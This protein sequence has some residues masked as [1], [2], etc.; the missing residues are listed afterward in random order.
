MRIVFFGSPEAALPALSALLAAGHE[1]PLVV[2]QPDRPAGRGRLPAPSPVKAF[3]VGLGLPT[4]EPERIRKDPGAVDRLRAA[5]P[6]IQ[7]VVAYGQIMPGPIIDLPPHRS[8]NLHFSLL[9][10]YRGA[11]PASWAIRRGEKKTGVTIFRLNEKMDEGDIY[12]SAEEPIGPDDTTGSL[13]RRLA[14]IGSGLLVRTLANLD[15]IA[16]RPQAH[17]AATYAPKLKKADGA[18]DW[19]AEAADVDRHIRSMTPWPTAFGFL[20]DERLIILAGRPHLEAGSPP[21]AYEPG[22]VLSVG[23][24]GILIACGGGT[25]Y[26]IARLQPEGRKTMDAAAYLAGGKIRPGL[27]LTPAPRV[28][29]GGAD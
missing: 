1:V 19:N 6:D 16:P 11:A 15:T 27:R 21:A 28:P 17:E 8:L 14:Q 12:A 10:A 3:A 7:V 4:Y 5:R 22:T 18:I 25:A 2:T 9:P 20:G 26:G 23:K 13:E 24:T 29:C